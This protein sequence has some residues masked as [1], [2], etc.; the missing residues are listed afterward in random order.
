LNN[1]ERNIEIRN[2]LLKLPKIEAKEG[3]E[4]ELLRK[5]NL[6]DS[7]IKAAA[8]EKKTGF[9]L[10]GKNLGWGIPAVSFGVIAVIFVGV[11]FLFFRSD[12]KLP[13]EIK[14][15]SNEQNISPNSGQ[16]SK[17]D[18]SVPGKEIANDLEIG[19]SVPLEK[20]TELQKGY[21]ETTPTTESEKT[22]SEKIKNNFINTDLSP[23]KSN[24]DNDIKISKDLREIVPVE[25]ESSVKPSDENGGNKMIQQP[26]KK[27]NDIDKK[28]FSPSIKESKSLIKSDETGKGDTFKKEEPKKSESKDK[29]TKD[30]SKETLETL[31]KK[32]KEEVNKAR[33]KKEETNK[34]KNKPEDKQKD[35]NSNKQKENNNNNNTNKQK[36]NNN[37]N[38]QRENNNNN[39]KENNN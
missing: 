5:I 34:P 23:K 14:I 21:N 3:F 39:R 16:S 29:V 1:D 19:K 18:D 22:N 15:L 27:E 13:S 17:S 25:K 8:K 26:P 31:S 28:A 33:D 9:S 7:P 11:Y 20:Q 38:N 24:P 30:V 35:N 37:N 2:R 12:L 10:F 32:I 4:N 6:L 36:E